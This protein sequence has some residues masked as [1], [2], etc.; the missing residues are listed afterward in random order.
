MND[1]L[2]WVFERSTGSIPIPSTSLQSVQSAG[3]RIRLVRM[4]AAA[5]GVLGVV[6]A[7]GLGVGSLDRDSGSDD[8]FTPSS[9][10]SV[11]GTE[12]DA[13][14]TSLIQDLQPTLCSS[15]DFYFK[16]EIDGELY[17][18]V[19][20]GMETALR[21]APGDEPEITLKRGPTLVL[22]AFSDP[23]LQEQW[24]SRHV[25]PFGGRIAG[26]DWVID[27]MDPDGLSHVRKAISEH[28]FSVV[29]QPSS[30]WRLDN[31]AAELAP[32]RAVPR[33]PLDQVGQHPAL[34]VG[35]TLSANLVRYSDRDLPRNRPRLS[36]LIVLRKCV[37]SYGGPH[38][39]PGCQ[40]DQDHFIFDARN[41]RVWDRFSN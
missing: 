14:A 1:E 12:V 11:D 5:V 17:R 39:D 30:T 8:R 7:I 23:E 10:P 25:A 21:Q 15:S 40:G 18:P 6:V 29:A 35:E 34:R 28:R 19:Q 32:A 16:S 20:C 36:W 37:P 41:G 13:L 26:D 24:L 27:V 4:G 38:A 22:Y 2:K 9:T 33:V 31:H 3:R